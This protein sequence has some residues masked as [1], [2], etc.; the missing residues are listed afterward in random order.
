MRDI[1]DDEQRRGRP[2]SPC[3][4][5][6]PAAR[7]ERDPCHYSDRLLAA[8]ADAGPERQRDLTN[9]RVGQLGEHRQ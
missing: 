3:A 2:Q 6:V 7:S 1:A 4:L 9:L 8:D 5:R